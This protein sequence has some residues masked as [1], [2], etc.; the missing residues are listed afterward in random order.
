[1]NEKKTEDPG[2]RNMAPAD[3]IAFVMQQTW[4]M[5][6]NDVEIPKLQALMKRVSE[7]DCSPEESAR[8]VI[9]AKE[10]LAEKIRNNPSR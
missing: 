1:M 2:A 4:S 9:E 7:E 3:E 8:L 5:G 10:V 6:N